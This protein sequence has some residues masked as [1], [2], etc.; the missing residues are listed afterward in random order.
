MYQRINHTNGNA[1]HS[2]LPNVPKWK[3]EKTSLITAV[4][5]DG[6]CVFI[7]VRIILKNESGEMGGKREECGAIMPIIVNRLRA[8]LPSG[9]CLCEIWINEEKSLW[10]LPACPRWKIIV[11]GAKLKLEILAPIFIH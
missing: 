10:P 8:C 5:T 7:S 2:V 9:S 3:Q 6:Q 1:E 4:T 11:L